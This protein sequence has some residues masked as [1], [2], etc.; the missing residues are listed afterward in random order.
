MIAMARK[1]LDQSMH[2]RTSGRAKLALDRV[3]AGLK[4]SRRL[5]FLDKR[6]TQ[7]AIIS[8]TWLWLESMDPKDLERAMAHYLPLLEASIDEADEPEF[9]AAEPAQ[10]SLANL[11]PSA[12]PFDG[13]ERSAT[14]TP[15]DPATGKPR[16]AATPKRRKGAS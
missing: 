6:P 12:R 16:P 4:A 10:P 11:D 13:T 9:P 1:G 3:V 7:E 15:R 5:T 2:V 14:L 8:A